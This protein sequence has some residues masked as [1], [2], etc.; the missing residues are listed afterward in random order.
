MTS[1]LQTLENADQA[2]TNIGADL[3]EELLAAF[4]ETVDGA[5]LVSQDRCVDALLDLFN[6]APTD[7]VRSLVASMIDDMRHVSAVRASDLSEGLEELLAA[8]AVEAAFFA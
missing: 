3:F 2:G 1:E 8:V 6:A 4:I 7:V 5:T